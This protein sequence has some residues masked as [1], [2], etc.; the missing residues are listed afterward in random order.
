MADGVPPAGGKDPRRSRAGRLGA[1][2]QHSRHDPL[3]TTAAARRAAEARFEREVD[4]DGVL[5]P[6]ERARRATYAKRAH[7]TRL[8]MASAT[9]RKRRGREPEASGEAA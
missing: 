7:F 5:R 9:A 1:L 2:V 4:P 6:D 3:V 8:A